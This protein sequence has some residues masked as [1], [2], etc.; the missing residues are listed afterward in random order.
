MWKRYRSGSQKFRAKRADQ[1]L[2]LGTPWWYKTS[3]L[4][5]PSYPTRNKSAYN[6]KNSL[7]E[8]LPLST[9]PGRNCTDYPLE[10]NPRK[11]HLTDLKQT[12]WLK[13]LSQESLKEQHQFRCILVCQTDTTADIG[14][15]KIP[16][17]MDEHSV[18]TCQRT[19]K[20][21]SQKDRHR[22]R[23]FGNKMLSGTF[24]GTLCTQDLDGQ[25]SCLLRTGATSKKHI[26][27]EGQVKRF[28]TSHHSS[29]TCD[30]TC[31]VTQ[32]RGTCH[33][34]ISSPSTTSE[35]RCVRGR[36]VRRR[37]HPAEEPSICRT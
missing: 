18:R 12:G 7:Q 30:S 2:N 11:Q 22:I 16:W 9:R 29:G 3:I 26:A 35:R 25:E 36:R 10:W 15:F 14:T 5:G 33:I 21:I 37:Q 24:I 13:E 28:R 31:A 8:F 1:D 20:L 4:L 6:T 17:P 27:S 23:Q 32:T 34:S 19:Y